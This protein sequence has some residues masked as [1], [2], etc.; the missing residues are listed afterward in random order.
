MRRATHSSR[1]RLGV[2]SLERRD[3]PAGT[4]TASVAAGVGTAAGV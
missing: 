3:T 2:E 4:V 1:P